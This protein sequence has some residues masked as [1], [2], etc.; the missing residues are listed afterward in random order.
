MRFPFIQPHVLF[1]KAVNRFH[2]YNQDMH[3]GKQ[4]EVIAL[5]W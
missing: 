4:P 5:E 3:D 2:F 1:F